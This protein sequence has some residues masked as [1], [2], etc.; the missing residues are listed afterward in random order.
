MSWIF[1]LVYHIDINVSPCRC[2]K[3]GYEPGQKRIEKQNDNTTGHREGTSYN[4]T[5][6][7]EARSRLEPNMCGNS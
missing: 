3:I 7:F 4:D 5:V 1:S 2:D 6:E